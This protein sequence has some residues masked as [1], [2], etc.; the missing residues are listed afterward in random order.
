MNTPFLNISG[1]GQ[2]F[3]WLHGMLNSVASDS[4]YSLVDLDQLDK[5]CKII[6]YDYCNKSASG[7]YTWPALAEEFAGVLDSLKTDSCTAGGLSMGAGTILHAAVNFP[8]RIKAMILVTPPPAWESRKKIQAVYRKIAQKTN[9]DYIPEMVK[10]LVNLTPDPPEYY[11]K[12]YPGVQQK[13]VEHRL[14][15]EP[16]YYTRIYLD[17]AASDFPE[18]E[19]ISA[20][21]VPTL[22]IAHPDDVNHPLKTALELNRL[23]DNSELIVVNN[24]SEHL[25]LQQKVQN[26]M[27]RTLN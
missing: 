3:I 1:H 2:P 26:F 7:N 22:I 14:S 9:A 17:G 6:R 16:A 20:I 27:S 13:L 11:A 10:R 21:H 12:V 18:R 4:V 5:T 25:E 19:Q 8:E 23:I 24:Y 15:F